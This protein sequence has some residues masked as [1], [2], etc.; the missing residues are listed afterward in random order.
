MASKYFI[1]PSSKKDLW[2]LP[3]K[4][5]FRSARAVLS[6]DEIK[7]GEASSGRSGIATDAATTYLLAFIIQIGAPRDGLKRTLRFV[8]RTRAVIATGSV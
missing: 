2:W 4:A 5:S 7:I 8:R 6:C 1:T 3:R